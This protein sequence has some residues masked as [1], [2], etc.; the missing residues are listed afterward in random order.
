[1]NAHA[2]DREVAPYLDRIEYA[3]NRICGP[4]RDVSAAVRQIKARPAWATLSE[5]ELEHAETVLQDALEEVRAAREMYG[6][7]PVGE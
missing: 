6:T 3:C 4:V 2:F 5:R 7:L 1:M